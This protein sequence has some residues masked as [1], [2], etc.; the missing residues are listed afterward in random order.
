MAKL[1]SGLTEVKN[2]QVQLNTM[3]NKLGSSVPQLKDAL[4]KSGNGLSE[5]SSGLSKTNNYMYQLNNSNEFFA[6]KEFFSNS[7]IKEAMDMY[8]S[9]DR[10]ITKNDSCF[11]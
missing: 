5:I 11:R 3:L 1:N 2:G 10:K 6:P 8:M 4:S 9:K 7:S